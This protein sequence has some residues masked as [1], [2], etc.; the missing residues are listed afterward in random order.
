MDTSLLKI[1]GQV[2]GIGGVSLGIFLLVFREIIRKKIF[3]Q[4]TKEQAYRLL[5]QISFYTWT[6]ALAGIGAWVWS[7]TH[8]EINQNAGGNGT[9]I[10]HTGTGAI[11]VEKT[12]S[13]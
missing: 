13:K 5:R 6:V 10:I 4:L 2:A 1:V 11:N 12:P 3:P 8:S 9:A 7:N